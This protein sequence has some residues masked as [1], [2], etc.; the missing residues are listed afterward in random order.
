MVK[1]ILAYCRRAF[2]AKMRNGCA[3]ASFN[4][5]LSTFF[6]YSF[7]TGNRRAL[8][9]CFALLGFSCAPVSWL[10]ALPPWTGGRRWSSPQ[11]PGRPWAYSGRRRGDGGSTAGGGIRGSFMVPAE[12]GGDL[13]LYNWWNPRPKDAQEASVLAFYRALGGGRRRGRP[14]DW[15]G[16]HFGVCLGG[17]EYF[18]TLIVLISYVT[19]NTYFMKMP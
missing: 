6:F 11:R 17:K 16:G 15:V 1:G 5:F 13:F 2:C 14:W 3:R 8:M 9:P 19:F 10:F 4:P 7:S 12:P 18:A